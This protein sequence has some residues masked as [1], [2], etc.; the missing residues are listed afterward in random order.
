MREGHRLR[1]R[2]SEALSLQ[3]VH[4]L[5]S[6]LRGRQLLLVLDN[7]EQITDA[8]SEIC[9]LLA[10]APDIRVVASSRAPLRLIGEQEYPVGPLVDDE[11]RALFARRARSVRPEFN[12]GTQAQ[13]VDEIC[14]RLDRLPLAIELAAARSKLLGPALMLETLDARLPLLAARAVDVP[15]RQRTLRATIAWSYDLLDPSEQELFRRLSVFAGGFTV[16]A[17]EAVAETP[18]ALE[19]LESLIDKS[20]VQIR[21]GR[22]DM[23]GTIREFASERLHQEDDVDEIRVRHAAYF[24]SLG[25]RST[26]ES[27]LDKADFRLSF[28]ELD[29][30]RDAARWA[31]TAGRGLLLAELIAAN[32]EIVA[33]MHVAESEDFAS[34]GLAQPG[35]SPA[36][37]IRLLGLLGGAARRRG[38]SEGALKIA[39]QALALALEDDQPFDV[40]WAL[41]DRAVALGLLGRGEAASADL[42]RARDVLEAEGLN[43]SA[44]MIRGNL[45]LSLIA[46][47]DFAGAETE[48]EALLEQSIQRSTWAWCAANLACIKLI[49]CKPEEAHVLVARALPVVWEEKSETTSFCLELLASIALEEGDPGKSAR[50]LA[51][52]AAWDDAQGVAV[53]NRDPYEVE[54]RERTYSRSRQLLGEEAF[55]AEQL[56]GRALL[57][58]FRPDTVL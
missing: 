10:G 55:A 18:L 23:L 6:F 25:D 35:L 28:A 50:L 2:L 58:E 47:G 16:A 45:A 53:L 21:D 22:F 5:D 11:A 12:L 42:R 24:T 27:R 31:R 37:R 54:M 19:L 33:S 14:A 46:D 9:S 26:A 44:V 39:D 51:L 40:G 57:E 17:S 56:Q 20:L 1:D 41:N 13:I 4:A 8:G 30:V 36:R 32:A 3:S 48:F 7:L 15:E 34:F 38:D 29:N 49:S 52:A 43:S